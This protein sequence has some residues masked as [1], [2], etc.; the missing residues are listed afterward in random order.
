MKSL[1]LVL[2]LLLHL[3]LQAQKNIIIDKEHQIFQY[4]ENLIYVDKKEST[5]II[6]LAEKS[7]SAGPFENFDYKIKE[8]D[9]EGNIL[10][11]K[12]LFDAVTGFTCTKI[13]ENYLIVVPSIFYNNI[14]ASWLITYLYDKDFNLLESHGEKI[15]DA[16]CNDPGFA[17][18]LSNLGKF[19]TIGNTTGLLI[20]YTIN[21]KKTNLLTLTF[22]SEGYFININI[23]EEDTPYSFTSIGSGFKKIGSENVYFPTLYNVLEYNQQFIEV[24]RINK[25]DINIPSAISSSSV[26]SENGTNYIVWGAEFLAPPSEK[27]QSF[28]ALMD[29]DLRAIENKKITFEHSNI[30]NSVKYS[31]YTP[32]GCFN[33][34]EDGNY[35]AIM[36]YNFNSNQDALLDTTEG[37]ILVARFDPDLN[38]I[39]QQTYVIPGSMVN[40]YYGSYQGNGEYLIAGGI[41]SIEYNNNNNKKIYHPFIG[42]VKP[43]C[44]IPGAKSISSTLANRADIEPMKDIYLIQNPISDYLRLS[45]SNNKSNENALISIF[46]IGGRKTGINALWNGD[47][48]NVDVSSL[49]SGVYFYIIYNQVGKIETGKFIKI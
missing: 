7:S 27:A 20:P 35:T 14:E 37:K 10:R 29:T 15:S 47:Q 16:I 13:G 48:G 4:Q 31:F 23:S 3:S 41:D 38:I 6:M 42:Y 39:C 44:S 5:Y 8:I 25:F 9:S 33:R 28:A 17:C 43:G 21:P 24:S 12:V 40:I 30:G 11:E 46:D 32:E 49:N 26:V 1:H 19:Y 36:S 45:S 34:E 22:D 2:G 18:G